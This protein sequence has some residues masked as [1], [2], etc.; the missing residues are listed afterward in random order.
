MKT[1][2]LMVRRRDAAGYA[3][4]LV[5]IMISV[6]LLVLGATMNRTSSTAI[7]NERTIERD[8]CLHAANAATEKIIS[9]IRA[10]YEAGGDTLVSANVNGN[11]YST[12][13][14]SSSDNAFWARY[15]FWNPQNGNS[16]T[17]VQQIS[18][19]I[20]TP[21][22]AQFYGLNGWKTMYRVLSNARDTKGL[23]SMA[24]AVQ[25]DVELDDIPV[26]QFAIFYNSLLEFTW[27][28]PLIVR[29]RV[30]ANDHIFTGSSADLT[31]K[32]LV[33]ASGT[34]QK[35]SWGGHTTS[36][37]TGKIY[38]ATNSPDGLNT[39]SMGYVTNMPV[40]SLPIGTNMDAA[41]VRELLNMPP[42]GEAVDSLMGKERFYNK[43]GLV[44]LV[45]NTSVTAIIK[46]A[47]DDSTPAVISSTTNSSALSSSF[48]FLDINTTFTDQRE[49]KTIKTTQIDM[50]KYAYWVSTNKY[51]SPSSPDT[52]HPTSNPLNI[53]YVADNRTTTSSQLTAVRLT[54]GVALPPAEG[55]DGQPTGF[56]LATPNPLYVYGHF[57]CTNSSY[58][59]TT[60]TSAT[61]P[62]SL[63][64]DALTILSSAWKD[65]KSTAS[66]TDSGRDAVNTTV[67]AAILTGVVYS[68]GS[69]G[70][71]PFSGGVVNLPRLL[72]DW[73]NGSKTL[74]LNTSIVNLFNSVKATAPFQNPGVYYY[75]PTRAFNFD[76]NFRQPS[77]LPPGTPCLSVLLRSRWANPPLNNVMYD[78]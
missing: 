8:G 58:L 53:L 33:T 57:N 71:S 30:H 40:L 42:A 4:L 25:Q 32:E 3:L 37:M 48:P 29:G 47:A 64:S 31:F 14:P 24:A 16:G 19:R 63:T 41:S 43:A 45:S 21:L 46:D 26:F 54:N 78:R 59:G 13:Y 27:A 69:T 70:N 50:G 22:Q 15:Q 68:E 2:N 5:L 39:N 55:A 72:E 67:N 52:K 23:Y 12:Y 18:N 6:S 20:Y 60:N 28:A 77:K 35:K 61:V 36:S 56:S 11:Q 17:Y 38:F 76:P 66:I 44:L 49:S 51:T 75:A 73:G 1:I 34:I 7:L 65:S 74:T 9:R 10:D 62:A